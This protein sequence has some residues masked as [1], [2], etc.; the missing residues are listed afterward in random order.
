MEQGW[1]SRA[2]LQSNAD[3]ADDHFSEKLFDFL[4]SFFLLMGKS[5]GVQN[6]V[7]KRFVVV[8]IFLRCSEKMVFISDVQI[9]W[10][11]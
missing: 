7:V 6:L 4:R 10:H 9:F 5:G 2:L 11:Y 1:C 3:R 8:G